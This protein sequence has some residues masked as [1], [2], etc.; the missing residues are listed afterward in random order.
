MGVSTYSEWQQN[1]SSF[2]QRLLK[3]RHKTHRYD[4]GQQGTE[5]FLEANADRSISYMTAQGTAVRPGDYIDIASAEGH[6]KFQV[7]EIEYYSNPAGMWMAQLYLV[8][9]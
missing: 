1:R 6:L 9:A 8:E 3:R 5:F 4:Q 7:S 2:V